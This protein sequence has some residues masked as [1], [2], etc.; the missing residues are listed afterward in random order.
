MTPSDFRTDDPM[1]HP[2]AKGSGVDLQHSTI[3]FGRAV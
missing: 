2:V 3:K 1:L